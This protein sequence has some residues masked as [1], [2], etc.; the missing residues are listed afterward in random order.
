MEI[1]AKFINKMIIMIKIY[2]FK[3]RYR[4]C[5]T[6][7]KNFAFRKRFN[8]RIKKNSRVDIG[9]NVFFNNDCSINC[10]GKIN[11]G[12]NCIFG[13]GVKLYDHNHKFL[14]ESELIRK[15]GYKISKISIKDN[16]WIGSNVVI[17]QGVTIGKNSIIGSG[18][19][20]YKDIPDKSIVKNLQNQNILNID[21]IKLIREGSE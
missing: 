2:V 6:I 5:L 7:G 20:V 9:S 11:I 12:N 13:E 8:L 16:C 3:F 1:L 18:C 4:G 14:D 21:E 19:I 17:L 10:M 15:Q